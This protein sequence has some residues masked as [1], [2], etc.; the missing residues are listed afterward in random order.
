M[1]LSHNPDLLLELGQVLPGLVLSGHTHGGQVRL[2]LLGALQ[3]P[4]DPR[5]TMGWVQGPGGT[6][7]YVSR[8]LGMSGLPLR[9]LCEPEITLLTLTPPAA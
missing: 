8:G 9:N 6:P 7:A 3:V 4:A 2:P 1:L 5:F